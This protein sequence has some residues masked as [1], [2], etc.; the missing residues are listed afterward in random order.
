[1]QCPDLYPVST[2][3]E[4]G[5]DTC[6]TNED[7]HHVLKASFDDSF[8]DYY[9]IGTYS[10]ANETWAPLDSRIDV[11]NG[12]RYDYGKFYA[13]KTF[14]DPS[15]RRRILWGWVNESDSQ[16]D[17]ISKGWASVQAIPRVV[18]L[19]RSTGMQLVMEPVEELKL[20]R[21]SHLHDADITLKKGTKKLIE[22]FSSMQVMSNLKAFKIMQAVVN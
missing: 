8:L 6:F 2:N 21:G 3:G 14:F 12:L 5:L 19:D 10:Q 9:A 16:Y 4:A 18:S 1:M 22:D 13:S 15:T 7:C 20:L 11:E 17:D